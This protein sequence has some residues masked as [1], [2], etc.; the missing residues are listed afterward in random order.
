MTTKQ[1]AYDALK[2]VLWE[3]PA[4]FSQGDPNPFEAREHF[5]VLK[6]TNV[7]KVWQGLDVLLEY[8][9]EDDDG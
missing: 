8:F 3:L 4:E 5:T 6:R 2:K 7:L 9:K 1:E